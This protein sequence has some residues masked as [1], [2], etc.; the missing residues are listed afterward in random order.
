M[1]SVTGPPNGEFRPTAC[2]AT[3]YFTLATIH[4]QV[5]HVASA[6]SSRQVAVLVGA[7]ISAHSGLPLAN[8]VKK[9]ILTEL[10][11][12]HNDLKDILASRLPFEA[13]IE[14]IGHA[15]DLE[16][17]LGLFKE[18]HPNRNHTFIAR[19]AKTDHL[20]AIYTTNF[21]TLLEQALQH[22][23]VRYSAYYA[24]S[25]FATLD[26]SVS[27]HN[28][29][30]CKLHGTVDDAASIRT[31][32]R[33][34]ASR[35]LSQ[36]RA[37]VLDHLFSSGHHAVVL[38]LGYSCSDTFDIVP[39]IR[40][41][42]GNRKRIVFVEHSEREKTEEIGKENSRN[43]FRG[44]RGHRVFAN[45]DDFI[46][47]LS[48][49]LEPIVG[50]YHQGIKARAWSPAGSL[51]KAV[52]HIDFLRYQVTGYLYDKISRFDRAIDCQ[53]EALHIA[54]RLGI[55]K[56]EAQAYIDIGNAH[57][58]CA[59]Y[60]EAQRHYQLALAVASRLTDGNGPRLTSK[61]KHNLAMCYLKLRGV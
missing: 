25:Q 47:E 38:I 31:T 61:V 5:K 16:Q 54:R 36:A 20:H 50:A 55:S 18:T 30:L 35:S 1:I 53:T 3:R 32:L 29:V 15:L 2:S 48:L 23:K 40:Q 45:T 58:I 28:V 19:L 4:E 43:P 9:A 12:P 59:D 13:F 21:D 41:V 27:A 6:I 60:R 8:A 46:R 7:G 39:H 44:Y 57:F 26:L 10:P 33:S 34:V 52:K 24:E 17:F 14:T 37:N 49:S 42:T 51:V 56:F 22:D 11:I